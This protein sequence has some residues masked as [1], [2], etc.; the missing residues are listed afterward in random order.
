[1]ETAKRT[2]LRGLKVGRFEVQTL[3]SGKLRQVKVIFFVKVFSSIFRS[4]GGPIS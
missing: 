1:M 3:F 2:P 4:M